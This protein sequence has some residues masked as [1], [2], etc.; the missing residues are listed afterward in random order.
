MQSIAAAQGSWQGDGIWGGCQ[1]LMGL[2]DAWG[3]LPHG[4]FSPLLQDP[5]IPLWVKDRPWCDHTAG[6]M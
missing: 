5:R 3:Q 2:W 4:V 1:L 6:G